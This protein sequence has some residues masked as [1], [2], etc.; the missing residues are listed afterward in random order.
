MFETLASEQRFKNENPTGKNL[1]TNLL[2][3]N[4][5]EKNKLKINDDNNPEADLDGTWTE[6]MKTRNLKKIIVNREQNKVTFLLSRIKQECIK[7]LFENKLF[8]SKTGNLL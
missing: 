4:R 7:K 5:N 2:I 1:P 8:V 6:K 3:L